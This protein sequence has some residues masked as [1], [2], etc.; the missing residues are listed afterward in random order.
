MLKK[1]NLQ[2]DCPLLKYASIFQVMV[3]FFAMNE[4]QLKIRYSIAF[5]L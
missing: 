2:Y 4:T 3:P 1:R 5:D